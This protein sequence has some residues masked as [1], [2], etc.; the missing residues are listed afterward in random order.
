MAPAISPTSPAPKYWPPFILAASPRTWPPYSPC[1]LALAAAVALRGAEVARLRRIHDLVSARREGARAGDRHGQRLGR[2][3]VD[4]NAIEAA[5]RVRAGVAHGTVDDVVAVVRPAV[6]LVVIA[7]ARRQGAL[8]RIE[9]QLL[10]LAAI[11]GHDIDLL[12][13]VVLAG[14]RDP[15][16]IGRELR[17]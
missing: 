6:N 8:R 13:A 9:G 11:R 10:R 4:G 5:Q 7:P 16:A 1:P 15:L 14:K 12:I 2:A 3:A 17:E